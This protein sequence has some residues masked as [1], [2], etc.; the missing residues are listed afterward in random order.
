[1]EIKVT[2]DSK[3]YEKF[4]KSG[5]ANVEKGLSR[6]IL[7]A[8]FLIEREAKILT[9]SGYFKHPTGRLSNSITKTINP[10]RAE[11]GPHVNYAIYVHEG[12]KFIRARPFMT[13]TEQSTHDEVNRIIEKEI[14][15]ALK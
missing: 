7:M 4:L 15:S 8:A 2:I 13:E 5:D 12:T 3:A 1:M 10:I 14:E 9:K 11:I 6:G